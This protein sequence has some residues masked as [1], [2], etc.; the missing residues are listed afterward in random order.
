M[1]RNVTLREIADAAGVA[2]STASRALSRPDRVN[3]TTREKVLQVAR[4]LGYR[5]AMVQNGT[6]ALVVPDVTNPFYFGVIRGTQAQLRAADFVHVLVDTE[7]SATVE[8]AALERLVGTAD[9]VVLAASRMSDD[10]IAKWNE[11]LPVATLNRQMTGVPAVIIDTPGGVRQALDHLA[12]L[13]HRRIAYVAG[14]ATSWSDATRRRTARQHGREL[15]VEIVVIGPYSPQRS[16]GMAAA[17]AVLHSGVTAVIA[18]ND[19]IAIGIIQ[20]LQDRGVEV[21]GRISVVGCDDAYGADLVHPTLT[22]LRA[23]IGRA[24]RLA[25]TLLLERIAH[26]PGVARVETLPT[27]LVIRQ[28]TAAAPASA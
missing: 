13:G 27:E 18:F 11:R 5:S 3:V 4:E 22:T 15:G 12:S 10:E 17:E 20:R 26:G 19:L 1:T 16:A 9:G 8:N 14:P 7:E 28:S 2:T 24:G 6:V 23:P 25:T 21:P